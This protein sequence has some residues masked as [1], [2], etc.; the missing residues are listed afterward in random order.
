MAERRQSLQSVTGLTRRE[1]ALLDEATL[2]VL[3]TEDVT[4]ETIWRVRRV[5]RLRRDLGLQYE[6]IEVIVR[7]L[8]RIETL[9]GEQFPKRG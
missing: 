3:S 1:L 9:E 8:D 2:E 5:R 6:A 7:L 4:E